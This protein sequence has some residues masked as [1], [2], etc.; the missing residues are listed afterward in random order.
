MCLLRF[1]FKHCQ[2]GKRELRP[3]ENLLNLVLSDT[4]LHNA[5]YNTMKE[6]TN[7]GKIGLLRKE[8]SNF[9]CIREGET[10]LKL[11]KRKTLK[12]FAMYDKDKEEPLCE[13]ESV[14]CNWSLC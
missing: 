14:K 12:E 3:I 1:I 8:L 6:T 4:N 2:Q 11:I 5:L 7:D 9:L 10:Q 13:I